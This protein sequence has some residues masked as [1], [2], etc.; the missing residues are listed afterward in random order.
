[1]TRSRRLGCG[2]PLPHRRGHPRMTQRSAFRCSGREGCPE[3]STSCCG[4]QA[5]LAKGALRGVRGHP[6][7]PPGAV[8]RQWLAVHRGIPPI[9]P[10]LLGGGVVALV[11][12]VSGGSYPPDGGRQTHG[13]RRRSEGVKGREGRQGQKGRPAS[14]GFLGALW[15]RKLRQRGQR[16]P[17]RRRAG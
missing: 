16:G 1:M 4:P 2:V 5:R 11:R 17:R 6:N 7:R 9:P 15:S 3:A 8:L 14:K 10:E 12:G 13:A